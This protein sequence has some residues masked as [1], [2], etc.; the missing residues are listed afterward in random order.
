MSTFFAFENTVIGSG[1]PA[2]VTRCC[3]PLEKPKGWLAGAGTPEVMDMTQSGPPSTDRPGAILRDLLNF[4]PAPSAER[5]ALTGED[6]VAQGLAVAGVYAF[7]SIDYPGAAGSWVY[8][9]EGDNA[10]GAF[11]FDTSTDV[12]TAFTFTDGV[13]HGR[14][15]LNL[16]RRDGD[17]RPRF[18]RWLL[19]RPG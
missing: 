11:T 17:Q 6:A 7:V 13:Y 19:P 8:D 10:V 14:S 5:R 16:V 2:A 12:V 1:L 18:D 4:R 9:G 3:R 15:E